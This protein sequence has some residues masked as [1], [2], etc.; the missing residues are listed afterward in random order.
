MV[1]KDCFVISFSREFGSG[2]G[3]VGHKVAEKLGLPCYD[4]TVTELTSVVSGF[5]QEAV[6]KS[7]DKVANI[8][9]YSAFTHGNFLPVYDQIYIAQHK[10]IKE[11]A[12]K[13]SCVIIGRCSTAILK[14][15]PHCLKVFICAPIEQRIK[16]ICEQHGV[17][18]EEAQKMI[19]RVD[20]RR[21][22]YYKKYADIEWEKSQ[23]YDLTINTAVG[24][25][26]AVDIIVSTYKA[27]FN[28]K[29]DK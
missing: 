1:N 25:D 12:Q 18:K 27:M 28:I 2:G 20:K 6:V 26:H 3:E 13:N 14:K 23:N 19:A 21:R 16:R 24:V 4:K 11:L 17:T 15:H 10:V 22:N 8:F 29:N 9:E 5:S 7:Q